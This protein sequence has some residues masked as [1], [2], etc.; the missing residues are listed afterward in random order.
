[1]ESGFQDEVETLYTAAAPQTP[2]DISTSVLLQKTMP[3]YGKSHCPG[4]LQPE[5]SPGGFATDNAPCVYEPDLGRYEN[6]L[7]RSLHSESIDPEFCLKTKP[8]SVDSGRC[9]HQSPG[10][11]SCRDAV[12]SCM[13]LHPEFSSKDVLAVSWILQRFTSKVIVLFML[14]GGVIASPV[15]PTAGSPATNSG[16]GFKEILR[17]TIP[18]LVSALISSV[19]M[20]AIHLQARTRKVEVY[21]L[22]SFIG[23]VVV[24]IL[25]DFSTLPQV[26]YAAYTCAAWL[27]YKYASEILGNVLDQSNILIFAGLVFA[28][29]SVT[30]LYCKFSSPSQGVE[31]SIFFRLLPISFCLV[32]TVAWK[33]RPGVWMVRR[34]GGRVS[35]TD[36]RQPEHEL[37]PLDETQNFGANQQHERPQ[38]IQPDSPD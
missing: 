22:F 14:V 11:Q 26:R 13:P 30:G 27:S 36:V 33:S 4:C 38:T 23:A 19:L 12:S 28:T 35:A 34:L 2:M 7:H 5:A 10:C 3:G 8:S 18:W 25:G 37:L 31:A 24:I 32:T 17:S 16:Y 9:V 29:L 20:G 6:G 15:P 1:M 21:L